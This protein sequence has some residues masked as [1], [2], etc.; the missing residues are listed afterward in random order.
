MNKLYKLLAICIFCLANGCARDKQKQENG[1]SH[2]KNY[3]L[4]ALNVQIP[5]TWDSLNFAAQGLQSSNRDKKYLFLNTHSKDTVLR[6]TV[7]IEIA[8]QKGA[9]SFS[10][11]EKELLVNM[12]EGQDQI[13]MISSKSFV[14]RDGELKMVEL[15]CRNKELN[16]R[17]VEMFAFYK[18][19]KQFASLLWTGLSHSESINK[20]NREV[21]MQV[22][23]SIQW[24]KP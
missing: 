20:N 15:N 16:M 9:I 4:E 13:M 19:D 6:E 5:I 8:Q 12:S 24:K 10:K 1:V 22:V 17:L 18:K 14:K 2:Y 11:L 23:N 21:F 3:D 7:L